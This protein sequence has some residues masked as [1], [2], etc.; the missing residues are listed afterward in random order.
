VLM[1]IGHRF[2]E[3]LD[4]LNAMGI[5][6]NCALAARLGLPGEALHWGLT[7]VAGERLGYLSTMLIRRGSLR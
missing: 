2:P 6:R 7:R 3:V 5:A 1:K 4:L